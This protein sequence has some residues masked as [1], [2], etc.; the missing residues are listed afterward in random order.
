MSSILVF[1]STHDG[2]IRRSSL[3]VLSHARSQAAAAGLGVDALLVGTDP[4]RH[5]DAVAAYGPERVFTVRHAAFES[6]LNALLTS[7]LAAGVRASGA[8]V[9]AMASTEAVKDVLGALSVRLSAPALPDVSGFTVDA[10]GVEALRP[11]MASRQLARVRADGAPVLVSVRSGSFDAEQAPSSPEVVDVAFDFDA[12]SLAQSL[13]EILR[14]AGGTV[15]LSEARVV[16]A[17]GRGV[18][19]EEGKRLVEELAALFGGAVGAS[20]AVVESGLFPATTQI[21]QTGKVVSPD[22]YFA[23]GVSGAIQHVAGM[24]NSRVIVAINKDAEAPIFKVADYGL[25]GDL[26]RILPPLIAGLRGAVA[27]A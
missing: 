16:V 1:I 8:R 24:V 6:P 27:S 13:R 20:R 12:A 10:A 22:L 15:D 7:A 5:V 14:A 19:D 17:A 25:V 4:G 2:R 26:Y 21:G 3:E 18:R 9:V 11:V 23:V